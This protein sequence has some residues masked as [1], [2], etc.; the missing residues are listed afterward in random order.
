MIFYHKYH[1]NHSQLRKKVISEKT[2]K[3]FGQKWA[4]ILWRVIFRRTTKG[5]HIIHIIEQFRKWAMFYPVYCKLLDLRTASHLILNKK[6]SK[7]PR[8]IR[9]YIR[10]SCLY[11][12]K[13][14]NGINKNNTYSDFCCLLISRSYSRTH[15][16]HFKSYLLSFSISETKLSFSSTVSDLNQ[17]L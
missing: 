15:L 16:Y 9:E 3:Y 13:W 4:I 17:L 10:Y 2:K 7:K 1:E 8:L 11:L 12:N 5:P 14:R 6:L